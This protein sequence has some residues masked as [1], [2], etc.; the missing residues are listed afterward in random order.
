MSRRGLGV[1]A[2]ILGGILGLSVVGCTSEDTSID[3]AD[4]GEVIS[5]NNAA[6]V[7]AKRA[8]S[9]QDMS[10]AEEYLDAIAKNEGHFFGVVADGDPWAFDVQLASD[11]SNGRRKAKAIEGLKAEKILGGDWNARTEEV[12]LFAAICEADRRLSSFSAEGNRNVLVIIDSG[13]STA[14]LINFTEESTR[15]ALLEPE[16]LISTLRESGD[17]V[18]FENIDEVIWF[19]LGETSGEQASPNQGT[20][21]AM[22]YF[23]RA[24]FEAAGVEGGITFRPGS[25]AAPTEGVPSVSAV[26]MPRIAYDSENDRPMRLGDNVEFDELKSDGAIKFDY[27]SDALADESAAREALKDHINQLID[28]PTLKVVVNGYTDT[29]GDASYNLDLS[30]RRANAVKALMVDAGVPESQITAVGMGEDATYETDEQ[31]RRVEI[32]L[33]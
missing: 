22:E 16:V 19:G 25:G 32:V 29:A 1:I 24:L 13:I 28:F 18:K 8:N 31:N 33:G 23:Y 6:F 10:V 17:L 11:E 21:K 15:E 20:T 9:S 2:L 3:L 26:D 27:D 7:Y 30:Q 14:G 4:T 5:C 12:D